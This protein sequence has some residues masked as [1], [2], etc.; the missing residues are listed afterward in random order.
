LRYKANERAVEF[1]C[2][3]LHVVKF[4]FRMQKKHKISKGDDFQV[5]VTYVP[6]TRMMFIIEWE[7]IYDQENPL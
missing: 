4:T 6:D 1:E 3:K 5:C 2:D 7:K